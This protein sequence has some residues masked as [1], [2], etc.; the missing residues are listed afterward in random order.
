MPGAS[1]VHPLFAPCTL[2]GLRLN[3][4]FAL[5]PMGQQRS[6]GGV[7]DAAMAAY[8]A[9]RVAHGGAALIF[10]EATAID[11][12]SVG[13][14]FPSMPR[15]RRG[16][17]EAGHAGVA[18][19]IHAAGGSVFVQ[20]WHP[21]SHDMGPVDATQALSPSGYWPVSGAHGRAASQEDIDELVAAYADAA[22][23]ARE[24]GYD[25]VEVHGTHGFLIDQF[26]WPVTNQRSDGYG[27]TPKSRA[28]F[29]AEVVAA[30]RAATGPDFPISFR[31]SQWKSRVRG[32]RLVADGEELA[33]L[34]E[35]ISAAGVDLF[36]VS[37]HGYDEAA[38]AGSELSL[39][40]WVRRITGKPVITVGAVGLDAQERPDPAFDFSALTARFKR[41]EFD[42][43]AVGRALLQ[44]PDWVSQQATRLSSHSMPSVKGTIS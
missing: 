14:Q 13:T 7:S 2:G 23:L 30:V 8:Y 34:I 44:Q 41:G 32:S 36:H 25:G 11:H 40:G 20:L 3:N 18:Q 4:R 28:R 6:P 31:L 16:A 1:A 9:S 39:A 29:A 26:L 33:A 24:L 35:P 27:G 37:V 5:A 10:T 17:G 15:L 22:A 42:L 21:G 19:A 12:S 38:F 43:V